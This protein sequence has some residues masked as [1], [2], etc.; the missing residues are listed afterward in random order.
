M[1]LSP[2]RILAAIAV[3]AG[4]G[5]GVAWYLES[6]NIVNHTET[7][8]AQVS[9]HKRADGTSIKITYDKL[10]R[11][12]FPATGV[13]LTNPVM[14][15]DAPG[16][17]DKV[18]PVHIVWKRTGTIDVLTDYMAHQYRIVSEGGSTTTLTSGEKTIGITSAPT[19]AELALKS[20][21][22]P[23]FN[24]WEKMD[25]SNSDAIQAGM[26]EI[27]FVHLAGDKL[28]VTDSAT[29]AV[30]FSQDSGKFDVT[31]RSSDGTLDFDLAAS[32]QGSLVTKEYN[33]FILSAL[34]LL[35][36]PGG[37]INASMPFAA[38]RAGKQDME[39]AMS[40]NLPNIAQG[41]G[42]PMP[43]G[44]IRISKFGVKNDY[45]TIA[46]PTEI[47]LAEKENR[48]AATIK[49]NWSADI[50][51]AGAAEM[52][53]VLDMGPSFAAMAGVAPGT[54]MDEAL[55]EKINAALPTVSTLGPITLVLDLEASTP[56][57]SDDGH[58]AAVANNTREAITLKQF[59]FNHK[60]WGLDANGAA[61][62]DAQGAVKLDGTITCKHCDT[63]TQDTI[64]TAQAAEQVAK[65][66]RPNVAPWPINEQTKPRLDQALSEIGTKDATGTVTFTL[67]TPT[68]NDIQLG[69]KPVNEAL[70]KLGAVFAPVAQT[71][72]EPAAD[73]Q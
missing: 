58:D 60:R 55:K 20:K 64:E 19:H 43:N 66:T 2:V 34:N 26:K 12:G 30:I 16:D 18:V 71:G 36:L 63:L 27:G 59:G 14:E 32:I 68:P 9:N 62:R 29:Q 45:Y 3:I 67:T 73:A 61:S 41:R 13:R 22:R 48:R 42:G 47:V 72:E 37:M 31:N 65:T 50:K 33:D 54:T 5:T 21:D 56:K 23:G 25:W 1:K 46:L 8:L 40:A 69:G 52:Q 11:T 24:T 39:I 44:S 49:L 70:T 57:P 7:L 10:S 17:G 6:G 35:H 28:E 53:R 51:P 4:V 15:I 38:E